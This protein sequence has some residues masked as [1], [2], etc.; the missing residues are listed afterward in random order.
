MDMVSR[1]GFRAVRSP[2]GCR[3]QVLF[4]TSV[5]HASWSK[6]QLSLRD[7]LAQL[8]DLILGQINHDLFAL[9]LDLIPGNDPLC[10]TKAKRSTIADDHGLDLAFRRHEHPFYLADL[11][12]VRRH[13]GPILQV[14]RL[15]RDFGLRQR[16]GDL[17]QFANALHC[18]L[19]IGR[20]LL[21][22]RLGLGLQLRHHRLGLLGL[23]ALAVLLNGLVELV[24]RLGQLGLGFGGQGLAA[25]RSG[26]ASA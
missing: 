24:Q 12:A 17:G 23:R 5:A 10:R 13:D 3:E 7:I 8:I 22:D 25:G 14:S 2:A 19:D 4:A 15:R 1:P 26:A 20:K 21:A 6:R 16:H 18:A 11:F 9:K